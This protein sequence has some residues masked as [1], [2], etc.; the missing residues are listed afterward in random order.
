MGIKLYFFWVNLL[1][2]LI[3]FLRDSLRYIKKRPNISLVY[4]NLFTKLFEKSVELHNE[5]EKIVGYD[6]YCERNLGIIRMLYE[7]GVWDLKYLK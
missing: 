4:S 3:L 5:I 2:C 6:I 1:I 7:D